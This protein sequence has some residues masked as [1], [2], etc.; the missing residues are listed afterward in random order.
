MRGEPPP[1]PHPATT[2]CALWDGA[3][4]GS[5]YLSRDPRRE[6]QLGVAAVMRFKDSPPPPL[7]CRTADTM[8]PTR[9]ALHSIS[10]KVLFTLI[11]HILL[12]PPVLTPSHPALLH[13][14]GPSPM[15]SDPYTQTTTPR[16]PTSRDPIH[17]PSCTPSPSHLF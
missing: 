4:V 1:P 12:T 2:S 9:H 13:Y 10:H 8:S 15:L 6:P 14:I 16:D 3:L 5:S 17:N 7:V 11:S